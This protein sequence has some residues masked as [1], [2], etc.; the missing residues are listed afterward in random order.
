M[1]G[2]DDGIFLAERCCCLSLSPARNV[3][4]ADASLFSGRETDCGLTLFVSL[5]SSQVLL[6]S[7]I[8]FI[9]CEHDVSSGRNMRERERERERRGRKVHEWRRDCEYLGW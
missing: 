3:S 7:L 4:L 1:E 8:S 5:E 6:E 2:G 9:L